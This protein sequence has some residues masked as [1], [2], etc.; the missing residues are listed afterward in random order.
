MANGAPSN[1]IDR[2]SS[3]PEGLFSIAQRFAARTAQWVRSSSGYQPIAYATLA[4][5]ARR[6]ASGLIRFGLQPGERVAILMENRPEW[7]AADFGIL[8]AGGVVV[9]LYTTARIDE[10]AFVLRDAGVRFAITSE[11]MLAERLQRAAAKAGCVQR[12]FAIEA[13][14]GMDAWQELLAEDLPDAVEHRMER[15]DRK[16]LA[17]LVYT[18]GTTGNPKGV[19]LTHGAFLANVSGALAIVELEESDL[20]LSFLPLAHAFERTAGHFLPYLCGLSVAY[21]ERPDTVAKNMAEIRPTILIAVPRLLEVI[22]ARI[23]AQGTKAKGIAGKLFARW[24]AQAERGALHGWQGKLLDRLVGA[25]IRE[26]FGG[27]LR[28]IV[29]G[30]APLAPEVGRFFEGLGIPV[31]EGYGLT[32]AA[33]VLTVNPPKRRKL[34]TVGVPLPNVELRIAEDGEILAR[35]PNIMRGYWGLEEET[36]QALDEEGFLHTGDVGAIDEDGHLVITDRKKDI[37]VNSGGENIAPQKIESRLAADPFIDQAVVYGDRKPYLVAL[38]APNREACEAWAQQQGLPQTPWPQLVQAPALRRMLQT[39]ISRLLADLA[40]Y[41]QVRRIFLI[42]EPLSVDS[43]L[44]TPTLKIKRRR[45]YE[46]FAD[47]FEALYKASEASA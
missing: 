21:A 3:L 29:S 37:L 5:R 9:P 24:L 47:R 2:L 43:G 14:E 34:G 11:G 23:V 16:S 25:R 40:P 33:P 8:A 6:V 39:R 36:K 30:G 22:R 46:A 32:E 41:E 28:M 19:M 18:S 44:V 10:L 13:K 20:L 38:I 26:R 31:V 15:I 42:E 4:E 7:A 12:S 17:S 35:G 27:R 45:V 1:A